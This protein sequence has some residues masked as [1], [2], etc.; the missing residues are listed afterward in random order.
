MKFDNRVSPSSS[1]WPIGEL[2]KTAAYSTAALRERIWSHSLKSYTCF[3]QSS[4]KPNWRSSTSVL[5]KWGLAEDETRSV[6]SKISRAA[7]HLTF[8]QCLTNPSTMTG[9]TWI[10]CPLEGGFVLPSRRTKGINW[11]LIPF[12]AVASSLNASGSAKLSYVFSTAESQLFDMTALR[13]LSLT[14]RLVIPLT[15]MIG[16]KGV[17]CGPLLS[18]SGREADIR[19]ITEANEHSGR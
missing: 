2:R 1:A 18:I 15:S 7:H 19:P 10:C 13:A 8:K 17:G 9:G 3:K 11:F 4:S 16:L 5:T 6:L 12:S 14:V